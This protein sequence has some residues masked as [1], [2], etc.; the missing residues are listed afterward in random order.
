MDQQQCEGNAGE[1]EF[2]RATE[3]KLCGNEDDFCLADLGELDSG[4]AE[5]E[6]APTVE[7]E[8][9]L[10]NMPPY[11]GNGGECDAMGRA[12]EIQ[13]FRNFSAGLVRLPHNHPVATCC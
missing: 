1:W 7:E 4:T 10:P 11:W 13:N 2:V 8:E 12:H 3:F 9:G 6:W 5:V